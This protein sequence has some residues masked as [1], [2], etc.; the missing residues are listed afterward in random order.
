MKRYERVPQEQAAFPVYVIEQEK[1]RH[2]DDDE[3]FEYVVE[4]L[5]AEG[6][7]KGTL[8]YAGF[9]GRR[10]ARTGSFG[11][12]SSTWAYSEAKIGNLNPFMSQHHPIDYAGR[13]ITPALGVFDAEKLI[14]GE[15]DM[16][17][18]LGRVSLQ[19]LQDP[20]NTYI[21]WAT[22]DRSSLDTATVAVYL[23]EGV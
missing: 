18:V 17:E 15:T 8:L 16:R 19:A 22:P 12:R 2:S 14:G 3:L 5:R 21:Y 13:E 1:A 11:K 23:F 4:H 10:V 6:I 7:H 20:D 9:S